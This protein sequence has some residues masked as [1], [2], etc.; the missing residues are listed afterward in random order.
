MGGTVPDSVAIAGG[1]SAR[2]GRVER[3]L[4]GLKGPIVRN[5]EAVEAN[6]ETNP[7]IAI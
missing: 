3:G 5:P 4:L 7:R 2:D 6:G 1:T